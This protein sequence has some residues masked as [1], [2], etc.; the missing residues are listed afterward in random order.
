MTEEQCFSTPATEKV[1]KLSYLKPKSDVVGIVID[2]YKYSNYI[3]R[4][5]DGDN[6]AE[7]DVVNK[8]IE[9]DIALNNVFDYYL[10]PSGKVY[11]GAA[12]IK[13]CSCCNVEAYS[14]Y[15]CVRYPKYCKCAQ[16]QDSDHLGE[17]LISIKILMEDS[18]I[19]NSQQSYELTRFIL[20]NVTA[21]HVI[22]N[23]TFRPRLFRDDWC[24]KMR[25]QGESIKKNI[26]RLLE[27]IAFM[28]AAVK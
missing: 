1:R 4:S 15:A 20:T 14:Y 12:G 2:T 13:E 25:C 21:A 6:P 5:V 7:A 19:I 10:T 22:D 16:T 26:A 9:D 24:K 8:A 18:D 23:V 28:Y 27:A 3:N 17:H 11:A